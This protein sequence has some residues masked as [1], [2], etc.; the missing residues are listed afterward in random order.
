VYFFLVDEAHKFRFLFSRPPRFHLGPQL[1]MAETDACPPHLVYRC[2]CGGTRF[3]E[4]NLSERVIAFFRTRPPGRN[5]PRDL[6]HHNQFFLECITYGGNTYANSLSHL[7]SPSP[8]IPYRVSVFF[9]TPSVTPYCVLFL[10]H[11]LPCSPF[12]YL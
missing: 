5:A 12:S 3:K 6:R 8:N 11:L 10:P 7:T 9:L 2:N 1:V 4:G